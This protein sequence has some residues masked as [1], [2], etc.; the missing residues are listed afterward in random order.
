VQENFDPP[1]LWLTGVDLARI[2]VLRLPYVQ[3]KDRGAMI[4][5]ELFAYAIPI[6]YLLDGSPRAWALNEKLPTR[7]TIFMVTSEPL[8]STGLLNH[9][10]IH[11]R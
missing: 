2:E 5:A 3:D 11:P 4:E 10:T 8:K 9:Y 6:S 7:R 1:A